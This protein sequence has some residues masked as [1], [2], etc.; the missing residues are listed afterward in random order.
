[1]WVEVNRNIEA[2]PYTIESGTTPHQHTTVPSRYRS[3]DEY[4]EIGPSFLPTLQGRMLLTDVGLLVEQFL[5]VFSHFA[6]NRL[7]P[8]H[9]LLQ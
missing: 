5:V 6:E 7:R 9:V 3:A 8:S 4:L 1:M 2:K